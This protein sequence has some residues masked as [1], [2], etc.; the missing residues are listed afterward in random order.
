[1]GLESMEPADNSVEVFE[2]PKSAMVP[3]LDTEQAQLKSV[4]L[5]VVV[6]FEDSEM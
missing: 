5:L 3:V 1:M 6:D 4:D 2:L